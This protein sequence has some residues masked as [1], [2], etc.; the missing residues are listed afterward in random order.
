MCFFRARGGFL[1]KSPCLG[2]GDLFDSSKQRRGRPAGS[3]NCLQHVWPLCNMASEN[4]L[5][6]SLYRAMRTSKLFENMFGSSSTKE[7]PRSGNYR[8]GIGTTGYYIIVRHFLWLALDAFVWILLEPW[9]MFLSR[10]IHCK[11]HRTVN[12]LRIPYPIFARYSAKPQL[13]Q[14]CDVS[15]TAHCALLTASYRLGAGWRTTE[16][17]NWGGCY[18]VS[19]PVTYL[20]CILK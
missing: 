10:K 8:A 16:E 3:P 15:G 2:N 17:F 14:L 5:G 4:R 9:A 11:I 1:A 12:S 20:P 18:H 7:M 19:P 13:A 6:T